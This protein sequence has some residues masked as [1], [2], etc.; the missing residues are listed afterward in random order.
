MTNY[1]RKLRD[2]ESIIDIPVYRCTEGRHSIAM[3]SQRERWMRGFDQKTTPQTYAHVE[4]W[5]EREYW[6]PWKFNEIIGYVC[7]YHT[8]YLQL[9]GN[10][11]YVRAMHIVKGV[12]SKIYY[13]CKIFEYRASSKQT[14]QEIYEDLLHRLERLTERKPLQRRYLDLEAFRKFGHL[15]DWRQLITNGCISSLTLPQ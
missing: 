12:K 6:Y 5:F 2:N 14:P 1:I 4:R 9:K 8:G 10:L 3:A 7:L 15:I 11:H 13:C